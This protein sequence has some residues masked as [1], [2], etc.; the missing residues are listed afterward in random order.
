LI[1]NIIFQHEPERVGE[2]ETSILSCEQT[3]LINHLP[4]V[5][6]IIIVE[7]VPGV[8]IFNV[9][10]KMTRRHIS[11][12][13]LIVDSP[14][15]P[16]QTIQLHL[17]PKNAIHSFSIRNS[18]FYNVIVL[19]PGS[20][21]I[22][23]SWVQ[24]NNISLI[25]FKNLLSKEKFIIRDYSSSLIKIYPLLLSLKNQDLCWIMYSMLTQPT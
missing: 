23:Q 12:R 22:N 15:S 16:L 11:V 8:D 2:E 7:Y 6:E 24:E 1:E 13:Y 5:G 4:Q 10:L 21:D 17:L 14:S 3:L 20:T 18:F 19:M 9:V 25:K